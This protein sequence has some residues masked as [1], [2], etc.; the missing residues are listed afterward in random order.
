MLQYFVWDFVWYHF[1]RTHAP[2]HLPGMF[3]PLRRLTPRNWP[4]LYIIISTSGEERI[5]WNWM[6]V[7]ISRSKTTLRHR[8][9]PFCF[10]SIRV[11]EVYSFPL[12]TPRKH[13]VVS[14]N[15]IGCDRPR[16]SYPCDCILICV[17]FT[18]VGRWC[19]TIIHHLQLIAIAEGLKSDSKPHAPIVRRC[20]GT[21]NWLLWKHS[22]MVVCDSTTW[23]IDI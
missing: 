22:L 19:Y 17:G 5:S 3:P 18:S 21:C 7:D 11:T 4:Q 16:T 9:W 14:E 15:S 20:G 13:R 12:V 6:F 1:A 2:K 23:I 10:A 8:E